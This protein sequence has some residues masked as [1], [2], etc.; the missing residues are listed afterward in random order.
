MDNQ[1]QQ[2]QYVA[3]QPGTPQPV[4]NNK[5]KMWLI[6]GGIVLASV[7]FVG[8]IVAIVLSLGGKSANIGGVPG[9]GQKSEVRITQSGAYMS[10]HYKGGAKLLKISLSSEP[11]GYSKD[12]SKIAVQ[13]NS[14]TDGTSSITIFDTSSLKESKKIEGLDGCTPSSV[15]GKLLCVVH[16]DTNP[17]MAVG[18][19]GDAFDAITRHSELRL[20]DIDTGVLSDERYVDSLPK[21]NNN[22]TSSLASDIEVLGGELSD[23]ILRMS[24]NEAF[25]GGGMTDEEQA[26]ISSQADSSM[27]S[28]PIISRDLLMRV[29]DGKIAWQVDATKDKYVGCGVVDSGAKIL[30]T[31]QKEYRE[32]G[33]KINLKVYAS[34]SGDMLTEFSTADNIEIANDGWMVTKETISELPDDIFSDSVDTAAPKITAFD[35]SGKIISDSESLYGTAVSTF[36]EAKWGRD[37]WVAYDSRDLMSLKLDSPIIASGGQVVG[38]VAHVDSSTGVYSRLNSNKATNRAPGHIMALSA[39]GEVAVLSD[40]GSAKG[41]GDDARLYLYDMKSG[42]EIQDLDASMIEVGNGV[43]MVSSIDDVLGSVRNIFVAQK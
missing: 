22:A 16:V 42:K 30:C 11:M 21:F 41:G 14:D 3:P 26:I 18:S 9:A 4:K 2:P 40:Y 43:M 35:L 17:D 39:N 12:G 19:V 6:I 13:D 28:F 38:Y 34:D 15:D 29:K 1:Q 31:D 25:L 37:G 33:E 27:S 8:V 36:P 32:V 24:I 10:D 20:L 23:G 5:K 7:I